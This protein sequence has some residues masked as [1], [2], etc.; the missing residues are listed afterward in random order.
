LQAIRSF[1]ISK[2][3]LKINSKSAQD[4]PAAEWQIADV[5]DHIISEEPL[6]IW[7]K[8]HFASAPTLSANNFTEK[9]T[10]NTKLLMTTMRSPG[11]DINLVR[12][13]LHTSGLLTDSGN[14]QTIAHAG[15]EHLKQGQSNQI[16]ITLKPTVQLDIKQ[17]SRLEYASS[18]CGV[19]GQQSIESLLDKLPCGLTRFEG[20]L[21]LFAI[22]PLTQ[23]LRSRQQAFAQTGGNH[24]AALFELGN[25]E[26]PDAVNLGLMDVREDVGRHNALDK[27]IG[28]NFEKLIEGSQPGS[29]SCGLVLSGRVSFDLVQK[30]AMANIK[31]IIAMG[32]PSSLAIEL[33]KECDICIVGFVKETSFNI[34]SAE[35]YI[36]MQAVAVS[37]PQEP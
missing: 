30:A 36:D 10:T 16:L 11:D 22:Y 5:S 18:S 34:Y 20:K 29:T 33:A 1:P 19:C 23:A 28:A 7:L 37:I 13:W 25:E 4:S 17:Y 32:A 31:L 3:K 9:I 24:G 14:I 15:A 8:Q 35:Q 27:L 6:E 12:G 2:A 21:A 26:N